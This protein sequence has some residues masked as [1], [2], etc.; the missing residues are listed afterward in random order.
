MPSK[1][2]SYHPHR[3][4]ARAPA[5]PLDR[6]RTQ[7]AVEAAERIGIVRALRPLHDK[8]D[9]SL[10]LLAYHRV[11]PTDAL[12]AY[13]FDRELISAT[14]A[15]FESQ[16]SYIRQHAH[17]VSLDQVQAHAEG[18]ST[19]PPRAVAVTFD[20]GFSDTYRY[21]F[22]ILKRYSIPA[23]IFIAT[24]NVDSGEPFWFELAAYLIFQAEPH[25]LAIEASGRTFPCGR[26]P[27]ERTQ[28]LRQ[29]H[30]ILKSVPNAQRVALLAGWARR[31]APQIAHGT[32]GH[33]GPI[34]WAQV[35]EM[36]A[37]GIAFGSHS[38]THPNLTKLA[39]GELD[40]E[41]AESKRTIEE[42]LQREVRTL[43]Y[44]IGNRDSFDERV[45]AAARRAGFG[46]GVS[47][48]PGAN[49]LPNLDIFELRRHGIGL[50]TTEGY[51]RALTS[52]PAWIH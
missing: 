24:G 40:W 26:T 3:S 11:M 27:S 45:I 4:Y 32:V 29:L 38:V 21:A 44:P 49:A 14:P 9:P 39:D 12:D 35:R 15:Q 52:L 34:S 31:F 25:A 30:E 13:P 16:M 28:S 18:K 23:T 36:A 47:Y 20:D 43:A 37:A 41:L 8:R 51:F 48:L 33:S 2:T 19:L 46:I 5:L 50:G 6:G 22:P 1:N 7:R 10:T 17:V 42:R